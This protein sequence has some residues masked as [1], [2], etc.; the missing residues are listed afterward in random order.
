MAYIQSETLGKHPVSTEK[1]HTKKEREN[2][3][4]PAPE[5]FELREAK[6]V[7]LEFSNIHYR[8]NGKSYTH[9]KLT[10]SEIKEQIQNI[11]VNQNVSPEISQNPKFL[12]AVCFWSTESKH[13]VGQLKGLYKAILDEALPEVRNSREQQLLRIAF[14]EGYGVTTAADIESFGS[15]PKFIKDSGFLWILSRDDVLGVVSTAY[16]EHIIG[17]N[18]DIRPWLLK[19]NEK[20][21]GSAGKQLALQAMSWIFHEENI[22]SNDGQ[23]DYDKIKETRWPALL[24]KYNLKSM[25]FGSNKKKDPP[26]FTGKTITLL[27][28]TFEHLGYPAPIGIEAKI[29]PWEIR[30]ERKWQKPYDKGLLIDQVSLHVIRNVEK[31]HPEIVNQQQINAKLLHSINWDTEFNSVALDCLRSSGI[32]ASEAL[33]RVKPHWFGWGTNRVSHLTFNCKQRWH[34]TKE[35]IEQIKEIIAHKFHEAGLGHYHLSPNHVHYTITE[36]EL[37]NIFS[38]GRNTTQIM[39]DTR[40]QTLL[41]GTPVKG[42]FLGAMIFLMSDSPLENPNLEIDFSPNRPVETMKQSQKIIRHFGKITNVTPSVSVYKFS[43]SFPDRSK[44]YRKDMAES[45]L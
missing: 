17:D 15:T 43:L 30:T 27:N 16:P 37:E 24:Q 14:C 38:N 10:E 20:W 26:Y 41:K 42:G 19:S 35:N 6:S 23:I 2:I 18:P 29:K 32:T 31:K 25:C 22:I 5:Q 39:K 8:P 7:A 21:C 3:I 13:S 9:C 4:L 12:T 28:T 1:I 44:Q 33:L 45:F 36:K 34:D 40:L 11:A